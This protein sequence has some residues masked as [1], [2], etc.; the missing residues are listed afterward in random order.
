MSQKY[1]A[2]FDTR[3]L[4]AE[5]ENGELTFLREDYDPPDRSDLASPMVMRDIKAYKSMIDGSMISSRSTHRDHLRAHN[6]IE[7][8]NEKMETKTQAISK[9][10][11]RK[12][13]HQQL[14]DLS[15]R[16]ADTIISQLRKGI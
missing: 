2:I 9:V 3:G 1:K 15:D 14:S 13:L 5:F 4:L 12:V 7:V 11:R 6:C 10:N 8:G 16:Q